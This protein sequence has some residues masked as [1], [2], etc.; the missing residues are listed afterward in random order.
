MI[1]I[2]SIIGWFGMILILLAYFLLSIK[3]LK[4]NSIIYNLLNFF[5]AAGIVVITFVT[6]AWPSVALNI[7][8][9][10]IAIYA[11]LKIMKTKPAYKE[12]K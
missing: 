6:K 12:L 3:K 1:D 8:W 2:Y 10:G 5:G 7:A 11:I 9:M 4:P